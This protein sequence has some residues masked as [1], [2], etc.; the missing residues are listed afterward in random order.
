[1][2]IPEKLN[3]FVKFDMDVNEQERLFNITLKHKVM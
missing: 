3:V 2:D 1:M